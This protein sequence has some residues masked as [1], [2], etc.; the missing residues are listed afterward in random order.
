MLKFVILDEKSKIL[1]IGSSKDVLDQ[2]DG[3]L[4]FEQIRGKILTETSWSNSVIQKY[5]MD[6][7]ESSLNVVVMSS[8]EMDIDNNCLFNDFYTSSNDN[9][10]KLHVGFLNVDYS[11][12]INDLVEIN[13]WYDMMEI[14][15]FSLNLEFGQDDLDYDDIEIS[16]IHSTCNS[17]ISSVYTDMTPLTPLNFDSEIGSK[18]LNIES[19]ASDEN[20]SPF[21]T[22]A[23]YNYL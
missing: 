4:K 10:L 13:S 22:E 21:D 8:T 15:C 16:K 5:F 11:E 14:L 2:L 9:V 7:D 17:N 19:Y 1:C 3:S 18:N 20:G 12:D 23:L 6:I